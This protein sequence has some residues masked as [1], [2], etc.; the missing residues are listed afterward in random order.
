M[1]YT[2]I[3]Q[4]FSNPETRPHLRTY[5]ED[6]SR[7]GQSRSEAW[8]FSKWGEM[9]PANSACPMARASDGQDYYVYEPALVWVDGRLCPVM[10]TRFYMREKQMYVRACSMI[11][12][13]NEHGKL[14]YWVDGCSKSHELPLQDFRFSVIRFE[15]LHETLNLPHPSKVEGKIDCSRKR[16]RS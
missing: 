1:R 9:A 4:E 11:R 16:S 10:P 3:N 7:R 8:H 5:P 14:V 13:M 2:H 12:V 6:R 15:E